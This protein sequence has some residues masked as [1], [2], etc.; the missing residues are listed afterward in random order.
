MTASCR[1]LTAT[2]FSEC[3]DRQATLKRIQLLE[4]SVAA[5]LGV[6]MVYSSPALRAKP[7]YYRFLP[8]WLTFALLFVESQ[9]I[10][11]GAHMPYSCYS[12]GY[13]ISWHEPGIVTAL[14]PG[15]QGEEA[16][17]GIFLLRSALMRRHSAYIK[18]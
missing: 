16:S 14:Q 12:L 11:H 5:S 8:C 4:A 17:A 7:G 9:S 1:Y 15:R 10:A 18:A 2:D 13:L 3:H 6:S